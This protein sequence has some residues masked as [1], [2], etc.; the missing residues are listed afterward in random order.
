MSTIDELNRLHEA[1]TKGPW[2][3]QENDEHDIES[4]SGDVV[5]NYAWE[6]GGCIHREDRDAIVALHNA[7]PAIHRVLVAARYTATCGD[8][9]RAAM[10]NG[11]GEMMR[12]LV[13][14]LRA[15]D[16]GAK[17]IG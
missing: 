17:A 8:M 15:L 14:A 5:G 12:D 6:E 3:P 16:G 7:W 10:N 11:H 13:E 1:A 4:D 2:R 9:I